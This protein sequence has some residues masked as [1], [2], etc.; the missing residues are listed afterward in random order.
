VR[1][2]WSDIL[3]PF[4]L[5]IGTVAFCLGPVIIWALVCLVSGSR[6]PDTIWV[7]VGGGLLYL[8]MALLGVALCETM[9]GVNPILV[10]PSILKVPLEY[11]AACVLLGLLVALRF[12]IGTFVSG[13]LPVVGSLIDG[14]FALYF[15]TVEMRI[16]GLTYFANEEK[17]G[18]F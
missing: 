12:S 3:Y 18:W 9:A 4:F 2:F 13:A 16:L 10:V 5:V 1:D 15:L 6:V 14:F 8:P 7:V 11:L 17:L